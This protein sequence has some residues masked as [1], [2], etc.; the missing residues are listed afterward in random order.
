M[1]LSD[2][3]VA[4]KAELDLRPETV[5][6]C[7]GLNQQVCLVLS[8]TDGSERA[9]VLHQVDQSVN[10][11]WLSLVKKTRML[12][13]KKKIAPKWLRIDWVDQ[14]FPN[15]WSSLKQHIEGSKR[16]YFRKGIALDASFEHL[17]LEQ[18][19]NANAMLYGGAD[20]PHAVINQ[21]NFAS[22]AKQ[23]Y[24][25][26]TLDFSADH[27]V[28]SFTTQAIF[29]EANQPVQALI[30][31]GRDSGRRVIDQLSPPVVEK[32]IANSSQFLAKQV[33]KNGRFVYGIHPCFDRRVNSYNA[34]RHASTTYSMLEA[35]EVTQNP[36]L[37][38][39]IDRSLDYL[40]ST[41]IKNYRLDKGQEVAFLV[42]VADEIKLGGNAVCLLALVK[43][44]ELTEDE[45][46]LGLLEKLAKGIQSMQDQSTGQFLHV[47]NA[48]D[49]SVKQAFR[50]IYYDGEAA[51]GLMRLYGLT[52]DERWIKIV[53]KAFDYFIAK[54]HWRIH[55]HWLS[56]CVNELTIY[57]PEKKYYQFG[58]DNVKDHLDF[59]ANRITTYPT[60]LELM[61]AAHKMISRIQTQPEFEA[62]L[63][64]ID[65][66]QFYQALEKR[67]HYLL[68]GYF[69]PEFAMYF[70]HPNSIV[71]SFF[72]RHHSFRVRIDDVEHYLSGYVAYLQHYINR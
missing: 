25:H 22:Y 54:E 52:R 41:L 10:Q 65:L 68:N 59:V 36:D 72:I 18:E 1:S 6:V 14:V 46:Y 28:F 60:L 38:R 29:V 44:T 16:N 26:L 57:R 34:L 63:A 11:A 50:I 13:E 19:L 30:S 67:A 64:Q 51:F 37:K 53:E 69:W 66:P 49:L 21:K 27:P 8:V 7:K 2:L 12:L 47:L 5:F 58:I 45:Q 56:Y 33:K 20:I 62:L 3:L 43:Y 39:S 17:F 40:T 55:D 70:K 9:V 71:G 35:W 48:T 23:R 32:L 61:M 4:A 42:D 31:K 15:T 24:P